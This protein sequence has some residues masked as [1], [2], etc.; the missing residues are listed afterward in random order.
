VIPADVQT[1]DGSWIKAPFLVDTGADRTVLSADILTALRFPRTL[2][3]DRI[4]G[5]G[6]EVNTVLVETR[7]RLSRENDGKVIFRGQY[8]AV[9]LAREGKAVSQR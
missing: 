9:I 5:I 7:L 4:G 1:Q 6:G 3:E 2:A 8:A